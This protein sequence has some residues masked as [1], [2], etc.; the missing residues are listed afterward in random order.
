MSSEFTTEEVEEVP[1][2]FSELLAVDELFAEPELGVESLTELVLLDELGV[3]LPV[4]ELFGFNVE[5]LFPS[6]SVPLLAQPVTVHA[7]NAQTAAEMINFFILHSLSCTNISVIVCCAFATLIFYTKCVKN[8][9][10]KS[11]N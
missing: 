10:E 7:K 4:A 1:E 6:C 3:V 11:E 9:I 5:E 2:E 8:T